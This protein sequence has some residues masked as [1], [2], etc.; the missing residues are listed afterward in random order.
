MHFPL[1]FTL[2]G[3]EENNKQSSDS[4]HHTPSSESEEDEEESPTNDINQ[5]IRETLIPLEA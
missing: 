3:E 5:E 2:E 1:G 4:S